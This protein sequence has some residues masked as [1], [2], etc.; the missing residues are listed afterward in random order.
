MLKELLELSRK[1]LERWN[2]ANSKVANT[3]GE[4]AKA[5]STKCLHLFEKYHESIEEIFKYSSS[6][7]TIGSP[8]MW[9]DGEL[10]IEC[11]CWEY[12][13]K[14]A[15]NYEVVLYDLYDEH[16]STHTLGNKFKAVQSGGTK[17]GSSGRQAII[18]ETIVQYMTDEWFEKGLAAELK[19]RMKAKGKETGKLLREYRL[20]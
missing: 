1:V 12:A 8:I 4:V 3:R 2:A 16:Y 15:T 10:T 7:F 20:K 13:F 5:Y 11:Y 9:L 18:T 6:S 19:R 17:S 14:M